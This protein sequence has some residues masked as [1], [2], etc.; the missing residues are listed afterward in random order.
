MNSQPNPSAKPIAPLTQ[1]PVQML[2]VACVV[3]L[4]ASQLNL[5]RSTKKDVPPAHQNSVSPSAVDMALVLDINQALPR[6]FTLLPS[7]GPIL[8]ERIV[9]ERIATGPFTSVDD[10]DRVHGMGEKK[11]AQLRQYCVALPVI[12]PI[13]D[14]SQPNS[15]SNSQSRSASLRLADTSK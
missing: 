14:S 10:L 12:N 4:F 13:A 9:A 7:V 5:D 15:Q 2:V 8:A 1:R 11:I 3:G 6:E